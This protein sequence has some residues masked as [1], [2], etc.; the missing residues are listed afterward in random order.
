[1]KSIK[2]ICKKKI[3][4]IAYHLDAAAMCEI[5]TSLPPLIMSNPS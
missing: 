2:N 3:I 4:I 1:M 5:S